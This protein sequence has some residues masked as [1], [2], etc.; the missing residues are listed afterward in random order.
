MRIKIY[1]EILYIYYAF[2]VG[3]IL[4]SI[5][6][7]ISRKKSSLPAAKSRTN[8]HYLV[9]HLTLA[10]SIICFVTLPMETLWRLTIEWHAGNIMC[11]VLMMFRTGGYI[12]SS[13]ILVVISIDRWEMMNEPFMSF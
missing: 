7:V 2:S 12:L 8:V 9:F 11:K 13:L 10:D 4:N 1:L 6:L 3:I 5:A